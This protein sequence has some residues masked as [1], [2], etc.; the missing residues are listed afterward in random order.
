MIYPKESTGIEESEDRQQEQ[1]TFSIAKPSGADVRAGWPAAGTESFETA[2]PFRLGTEDIKE[3]LEQLFDFS[4]K[5]GLPEDDVEKRVNQII[6][7]FLTATAVSSNVDI[8]I[9]KE[10]FKASRI[11]H[12]PVEISAYLDHLAENVVNHSINMASPRWIGHMTAGLP[13]FVRPL[14]KLLTTLNQNVVK[15]E[16]SK[17]FTPYERQSLA[18]MHRLVYNLSDEFYNEHI[19]HNDSTLGI[20]TSGGTL[21]NL[22]ALWCARNSAL[23][24]DDFPGVEKAGWAAALEHYGYKRAVIIGS[25]L[26]HYSFEKSADILGIGTQGLIR[27]PADSQ[28]RL[29]NVVPRSTTS[30]R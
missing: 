11:P 22:T 30:W 16:T 23:K 12:R 19:Q 29:Q 10:R 27:V 5:P 3:L 26:M 4:G 2:V 13:Y 8:A 6:R 28:Q 25:S 7:S 21:A 18:M 17:S 24:S 9:L 1:G 15:V 14:S 20:I